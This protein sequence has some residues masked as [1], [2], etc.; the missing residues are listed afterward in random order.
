[1][2]TVQFTVLKSSAVLELQL[3]AALWGGS[4]LLLRMLAPAFGPFFLIESRVLAGLM[5]LLPFLVFSPGLKE[6][7]AH[8]RAIALL[9]LTNMCLPFCLL[10]FASLYLGAGT[11]SILNATVPFFAAATGFFLFGE[12]LG[13]AAVT[14]LITGFTGVVLLMAGDVGT[15]AVSDTLVAFGAGLTAA[16]FYGYS[17]NVINHRLLGVSGLAITTGSLLCT[18]IYLLPTLIWFRPESMP[19]SRLWLGVLLLGTVC[20]GLPYLIFYRLIMRIGAYQTLTVT[21]LVPVFSLFYGMIL[22][23][24]RVTLVMLFGALM[25]MLGVAITTGRLRLFS[26]RSK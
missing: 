9:S 23:A 26:P 10:A 13:I 21:Y 6:L 8:W 18:S 22:L 3:L 12:R 14:G 20:T 24:E 15:I 2:A 19:E 7:L 17:A 25:V 1:M 4:F 11:V 16:F 5:V